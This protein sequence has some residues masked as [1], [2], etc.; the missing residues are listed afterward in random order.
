MTLCQSSCCIEAVNTRNALAEL[1]F[2]THLISVSRQHGGCE[3]KLPS[4]E[5]SKLGRCR[6][7]SYHAVTFLTRHTRSPF[8]GCALRTLGTLH[9]LPI[10]RLSFHRGALHGPLRG[11]CPHRYTVANLLRAV[12]GQPCPHWAYSYGPLSPLYRCDKSP[13]SA[14]RWFRVRLGSGRCN[15]VVAASGEQRFETSGSTQ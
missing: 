10:A 7:Q 12:K 13:A 9:M 6:L 3:N 14:T 4:L 15:R 1:L 5:A 11:S 2:A 8:Q